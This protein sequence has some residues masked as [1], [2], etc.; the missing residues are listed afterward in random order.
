[1]VEN[2]DEQAILDIDQQADV[3]NC[4]VTE[5]RFDPGSGKNGNLVLA[6]YNVT[7]PMEQGNMPVTRAPDPPVAARG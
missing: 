6:R 2:L 5:Y 1:V 7:A 4:A 3:A